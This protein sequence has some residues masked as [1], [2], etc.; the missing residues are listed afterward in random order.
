MLLLRFEL[1]ASC[2]N[3]LNLILFKL[4]FSFI[5]LKH[6]LILAYKLVSK[7]INRII[8]AREN[9]INDQS[10]KVL[11]IGYKNV[12][13]TD[14]SKDFKICDPFDFEKSVW[15]TIFSLV[16]FNNFLWSLSGNRKCWI[17]SRIQFF[18]ISAHR[19]Q[20]MSSSKIKFIICRLV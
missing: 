9:Q 20:F 14:S 6:W 2:W 19:F 17:D 16:V 18:I 7:I 4:Q 3:E 1:E 10:L 13:F 8:G 5:W 11:I 15:E 12:I